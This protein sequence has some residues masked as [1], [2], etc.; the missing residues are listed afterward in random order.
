MTKRVLLIVLAI[1]FLSVTS[2]GAG[3]M[4]PFNGVALLIQKDIP[5]DE[6]WPTGELHFDV[7]GNGNLTHMGAIVVT[8]KVCSWV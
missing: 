7:T 3:T 2:A 4:V 6:T 8:E 1:F 5:N